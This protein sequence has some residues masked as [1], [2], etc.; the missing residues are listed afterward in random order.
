MI[1]SAVHSG[2][3]FTQTGATKRYG[4]GT[5]PKKRIGIVPEATSKPLVVVTREKG[6]NEKLVNALA[7]HDLRCL[8]LPL[9]EHADG[10]DLPK[11]PEVLKSGGHD[12][13]TITSPHSAE[14]F[15]QGWR[16]AGQPSCRIA[17]VGKATSAVLDRER[18]DVEF[19]PS[20]SNAETLAAELPPVNG[21]PGNVL[22]V[23][24]VRARGELE[25]GLLKRGFVVTRLNTYDTI[26]VQ[27]VS[28]ADLSDALKADVVT[29]GSPSAIG[30]WKKVVQDKVADTL[31]VAC[32]GAT[33][34]K[35]AI[36]YGLENV[37][38]PDKPGMDGWVQSVL[39]ALEEVSRKDSRA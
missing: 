28:E 38:Y 19:T 32:I 15:C 10:P 30:A 36:E 21:S 3:N 20:K 33:S 22:Y 18:I 35:A 14:V 11:L 4:R 8:E 26:P 29:F 34:G 5:K 7:K 2:H 12:W 37:H 6:M 24:S 1:S 23:A 17:T 13:V 31:A 39:K 27:T 25:S 16:S 9:I